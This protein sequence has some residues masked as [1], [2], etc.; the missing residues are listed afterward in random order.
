MLDIPI[1]FDVSNALNLY[2]EFGISGAGF[3]VGRKC[4]N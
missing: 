4:A 1:I 2:D 3:Y